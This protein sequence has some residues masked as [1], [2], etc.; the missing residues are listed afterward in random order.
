MLDP[1]LTEWVSQILRWIHVITAVAWIGSSFY[2]IHLDLSLRKREGLAAGVGG[3]A[4]QVHGGGF[5]RMQKYLVAPPEL[6]KELTWFKWESYATWISGFSLIVWI[7][8]LQADLYTID[9]AVRGLASWQAALIGIGGLA[10]SW[11]VYDRLCKSPLGRND[12]AL[13]TVLFVYILAAAWVFTKVFSGRAAFLHTGAMIATWMT[14]S[15]AMV[16]IPNQRKTVNELLAGRAPDPALGKQ[17][18]QRSLHNNYLTLPVIFLMLANHYPLSWQSRYSVA[19]VGL[20][21]VAGAVIRHF[22]NSKHASG[23]TPWWTWGVAAASMALA[24]YLSVIGK[25]GETATPAAAAMAP[26]PKFETAVLAIQSRCS[27]C[28][29]NEPSWAG[30]AA[31]PKGVR[32][33]TPD[34]I[35]RHADAIRVQAVM[36]HAM[37]PNNVT[38]MTADERRAVADW[39]KERRG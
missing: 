16:I 1:H 24:A 35:A 6:P 18:K 3:E 33:D 10:L 36:T 11:V 14:A 9:P 4:W 37:P 26:T 38:E 27:M 23:S 19:I 39:L 29:M 32:L 15:V 20:V 5:Y 30:L 8:Y 34:E 28:H 21:L 22:F 31:P 13:F 25:P 17:A 12:V 2:F 7:Y